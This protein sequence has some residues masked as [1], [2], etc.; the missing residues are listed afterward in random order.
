MPSPS[1]LAG[2]PCATLRGREQSVEGYAERSPAGTK[3]NSGEAFM[4]FNPSCCTEDSW[5]AASKPL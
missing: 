4:G 1:S 5:K 3:K 2:S